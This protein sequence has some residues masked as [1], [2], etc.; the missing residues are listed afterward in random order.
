MNLRRSLLVCAAVA[1]L[2]LAVPGTAA[3]DSGGATRSAATPVATTA[4]IQPNVYVRIRNDNSEKCL[5][6]QGTANLAPVRQVG[7]STY[8]DQF[9]AFEPIAGGYY[10]IR[11]YNSGRC[12]VVQGTQAGAQA[13]QVGC[14]A[15][16]DQHWVAV[17]YADG[18]YQLI[19][20]NS[21]LCL[22]V[23]GTAN[24]ATAFQWGCS[25]YTDQFWYIPG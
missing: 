25:Y 1:A 4:A 21:G 18:S 6:V 5:V 9:W 15:Y 2:A 12:I 13:K 7:C 17:A 19:N 16:A 10:R 23:Q 24:L 14:G 22:V 11:N 20:R 3:A 8:A